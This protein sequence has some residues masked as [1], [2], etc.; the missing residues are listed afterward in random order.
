[1]YPRKRGGKAR[2]KFFKKSHEGLKLKNEGQEEKRAESERKSLNAKGRM[3]KVIRSTW[4]QRKYPQR[5]EKIWE[6]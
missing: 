5:K 2:W 6:G 3:M 4:D 1:L